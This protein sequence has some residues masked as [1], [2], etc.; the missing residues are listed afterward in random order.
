MAEPHFPPPLQALFPALL[1][2]R[3]QTQQPVQIRHPHQ[4]FLLHQFE[5]VLYVLQRAAGSRGAGGG[6]S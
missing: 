4:V 2:S 6:H 3:R 1:K 5:P